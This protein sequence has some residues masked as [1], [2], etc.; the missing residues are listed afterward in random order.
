MAEAILETPRERDRSPAY[1]AITL[2]AALQRLVSFYSHFK[3]SPAR[4]D[5]VGAAWGINT[6]ARASRIAA[7]L[8]YFGLLSYQRAGGERQ[9][10]ISDVG[11]KYLL[12]EQESVKRQVIRHAALLPKQINKL[13]VK[14]ED[15]RPA[16]AACLDALTFEHGFSKDGARRFL[17][18]YDE[19]ISFAGLPEADK[20]AS[21][22]QDGSNGDDP[23]GD[24]APSLERHHRSPVQKE[25]PSMKEDV[26]T[27]D[28][29]NAVLQWP[30]TLSPASHAD[31][32]DWLDL[33][34]RKIERQAPADDENAEPAA[35]D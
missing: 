20:I 28:E 29:G 30:A 25:Q 10:T 13:W 33:M 12:A 11:E 4:L 23:S 8:S 24:D 3:R 19:T 32:K 27:L 31:L 17:K 22:V 7:A 16:E 35:G 1:P 21:D 26:F 34:L 5:N 9:I 18:I 6:K 2:E 14:W 15:D